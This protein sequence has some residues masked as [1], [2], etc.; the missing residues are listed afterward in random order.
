MT[1]GQQHQAAVLDGDWH[2]G[3]GWSA[4]FEGMGLEM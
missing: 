1:E 2:S 4:D 3:D